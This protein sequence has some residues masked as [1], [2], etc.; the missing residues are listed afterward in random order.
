MNFHICWIISALVIVSLAALAGKITRDAWTG[1]LVD[2]RG[3]F[4][5]N[6]LQIVM[7]TVLVLSSVMAVFLARLFAGESSLLAFA[8]PQELL[9]LMG[10]SVGSAVVASAAK[11]AKDAPGS[12]ARVARLGTQFRLAGGETRTISAHFGQV[13]QV[14]EGDRADE[15]V[16]ITKFQN[17]HFYFVDRRCLRGLNLEA[18]HTWRPAPALQRDSLALGNQPRWIHRREAS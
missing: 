9:I 12:G 16:D 13:F 18:G 17:F 3:R 11:G 10:I 14:E 8:I 5:L 7:W 4:S 2:E 6:H 1:I 15:V